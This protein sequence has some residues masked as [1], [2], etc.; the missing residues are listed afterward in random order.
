MLRRPATA[1]IDEATKTRELQARPATDTDV[2]TTQVQ[3]DGLSRASTMLVRS[4]ADLEGP[5]AK[6]S[7]PPEPEETVNTEPSVN[8]NKPVN[9]EPT[10]PEETVSKEPSVPKENKPVNPEPPKSEETVS[11][12]PSIPKVPEN[13]PVNTEPPKSEETISKEPSIA[14][15]PENKPVNQEPPKQ[16]ETISKEP[17]FP[18]KIESPGPRK[19]VE[20]IS[21]KTVKEEPTPAAASSAAAAPVKPT[22]ERSEHEEALH[23]EAHRS[24]MRYYR[25]G[26]GVAADLASTKKKSDP[27]GAGRWWKK[28]PDMPDLQAREWELFKVFDG[29][30]EVSESEDEVAFEL[31][32]AAE[33]DEGMTHAAMLLAH[34]ENLSQVLA[35]TGSSGSNDVPLTEN[36]KPDNKPKPNKLTKTVK[37]AAEALFKK[38]TLKLSEAEGIETMLR[39]GGMCLGCKLVLNLEPRNF[40]AFARS[41]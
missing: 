40:Q 11:K 36:P 32:S 27:T 31:S 19:A 2:A 37:Q 33:L 41:R 15:V 16:G 28:H 24:Y 8:E 6:C 12:E 39:K 30:T 1:D 4:D 17:S 35:G 23:K 21:P 7:E 38:V 3:P 20:P 10:K 22:K 18:V 29:K 9:Q 34:E 13:K 14:K 25:H 5:P 26:E